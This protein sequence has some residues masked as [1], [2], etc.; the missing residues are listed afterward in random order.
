MPSASAALAMDFGPVGRR[1]RSDTLDAAGSASAAAAKTQKK[2]DERQPKRKGKQPKA[3]A[4]GD[5]DDGDRNNKKQKDIVD[6]LLAKI[7][8]SNASQLRSVK[9]VVIETFIFPRNLA[10]GTGDAKVVLADSVKEITKEHFNSL[11]EADDEGKQRLGPPHILVWMEIIAW[12]EKRMGQEEYNLDAQVP[13]DVRKKQEFAQ[14]AHEL[15]QK[16]INKLKKDYQ[17]VE[18]RNA[19]ILDQ[20]KHARISNTYRKDTAKMEIALG[21]TAGEIVIMW[22]AIKSYMT[23][24]LSF[25]HK[26]GQAPRS[27]LERLIANYLQDAGEQD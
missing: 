12:M 15:V 14:K 19:A 25:V 5:G 8:L 26:Q 24:K 2:A 4:P 7:S 27:N 18:L 10:A 3:E 13:E 22:E 16:Y 23:T 1:Q 11:R 21:P 20:I 6:D 17:S 9:S